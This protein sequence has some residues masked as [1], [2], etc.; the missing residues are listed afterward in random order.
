MSLPDMS[1]RR[2]VLATVLN[3]LIVLIGAVALTRLPVRELPQVDSARLS[4]VVNYT[5]ASPDVVDSQV[6]SVVEGAL[7]GIS[8]LESIET[9]SERGRSRTVLIFESSRDIDSAANDV[10]TAMDRAARNLPDGADAPIV[11]KNDSQSDPVVRLS[12]SS[13]SM[14]PLELSDYADRYITDRLAR[15]PGVANAAIFGQRSPAM[16][17]WLD[18]D[19]M[20]AHGVTTGD[21]TSAL[22]A[23]NIELPAG[24]I[25]TGARQLQLLART[26]FG[27]A[28]DFAGLVIRDDGVR[29]LRLGDV[30]R[31]ESGPSASESMFRS[32]GSTGLGL[33]IQAQAQ[34]NTVAISQAVK[35]E[36]ALMRPTLPADMT[37]EI[38]TDEALFIE[39]T[40]NEVAHV[41]AEAVGLVTA[42]IFLFLGS[43]RLSLVPVVT[44]PVSI[45]GAALA[46][47][48]LGFTINIMTLFAMILAIG[49]V[50]DDAIVVLENIQRHRAMGASRAEA[51]RLGANQV[52]F[53]V[54]AT[55]AVLIAVFLPVSFMEGQIGQIFAEFGIVLAVAVSVSGFVALTLS[56]AL[57]AR[58]MPRDGRPNLLTR[59]VNAVIG[60]IERGYRKGLRGVMKAPE[61]L[62]ALT[63]F[64]VAGS[65]AL[66]QALPQEVTPEEDRG[67]FR[68]Y[69]TAPQ[70]VNL[71]YTDA[72]VRKVEALIEP[73]REQGVVTNVT[74]IVGMWGELRRAMLFVNL[75][76]WQ[77]R[78]Q[79]VRDV[80]ADLRGPLAGISE[81]ATWVRPSS[82]LRIGGGRG[83]LQF[84]LGGP[85]IDRAAEWAEELAVVLEADPDLSGVEVGHAA[86]QPGA[87]LSVDRLRAQD[88]GLDAENVSS[89][90]RTLIAS[91]TV[92]EYSSNG[93]Q[94]PVILQAAPEDRD[95]PEDLMSILLRN[96]RGD[97]VPLSAFASVE[98]EATVPGIKRYNRVHSVEM[99]ADLVATADLAQVMSRVEAAVSDLPAGAT[100]AWKGQAADFLRTSGGMTMVFGMALAIV[101]LV[102]AAQFES[103]RTPL[104]I[105]LTV[106]LGLSGAVLTLWLAGQ[107]VNIFSQVGLVLLVGLMAKNGILVVEFANQLR[108]EGMA[109]REAAIEG[110]V[111]RLRPVTMT[112]IATVL[113]AVPLAMADG[114]GAESR[115]AIGL[116]ITGG[117]SL[118]FVLTLLVTPVIYY[119]IES[120]RARPAPDTES[121]TAPT[122]A[123]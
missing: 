111:T 54:I 120:I 93:R 49:L 24:E 4:I 58:L 92:G 96:D 68:I 23:N 7:A 107:T 21:I 109:L 47:L 50:V 83:G 97:L 56:P 42:V 75:V 48:L 81:V 84:M 43:A 121:D 15:L 25:D 82:G 9:E 116:V 28:E 19:L 118:A 86:N 100:I 53:A 5:G 95:S 110:A 112:T 113:G 70:G 10:R 74:T 29:P 52:N 64:A 80:I 37:L 39:T 69:V 122:P 44:I 17:I 94:Y 99:E 91:R 41:F 59:G 76:P 101:F 40:L 16:R 36:L 61:L 46:M 30:A 117:L 87:T 60:W 78:D 12:L 11:W 119:L 3:L 35:A 108:E 63:A 26:R 67:Q 98:T 6:A 105:M 106:P 31:I 32:D 27:S 72:A 103:F 62:L 57:A 114:A 73:L 65:V 51:A 8:G 66:Y 34:A 77:E 79:S 89:T 104:V 22:Q 20:A 71:D 115:I 13:A 45:L 33:G 85:D 102:L 55:T 38:T 123:E 2:P 88:L 14:S 1:I 18:A 90:L